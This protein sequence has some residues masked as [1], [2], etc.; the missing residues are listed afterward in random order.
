[1]RKAH[2]SA[3]SPEASVGRWREELDAETVEVFRRELGAEL[4]ALGFEV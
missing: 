1:M 2:V 3:S 4:E